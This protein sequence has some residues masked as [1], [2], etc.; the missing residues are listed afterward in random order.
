MAKSAK[1][2][3]I[4]YLMGKSIVHKAVRVLHL[5]YIATKVLTFRPI[6][7]R[8]RRSGCEYRVRFLESLLIADE[9]FAR[10][11][12]REAFEGREIR[13]FIDLGANVGFFTL[14]AADFTG[15]RDLVGL[16]VDAN[17][18]MTDEVRW[19]LDHNRL[20]RTRVI[21]G[22]AGY[23]PAVTTAIF[24]VNPSNVA[25]SAQPALNPGVPS[26][27]DS[28]PQTVPTVDVAAEWKATA[29]HRRVDLLKID[30]EGFE[31]DLIRNSLE[32]CLLTDRIVIE[33]HKWV[34]SLDEVDGLLR[35]CGFVRSRIISEDAHAGIAIFDRE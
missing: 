20:T 11:I 3:L 28:V 34:T 25:S 27:G 4:G 18:T 10:E 24:F 19:H 5:Q 13:T 22:V 35:A 15:R 26:K 23:P 2:T 16:S 9:I 32:L 14:Y 21:T 6:K 8:L 17:P 30:V 12:Y 31:C 29:G 7:R 33:W 1:L